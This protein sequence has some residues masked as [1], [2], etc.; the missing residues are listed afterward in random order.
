[1]T[2]TN[3]IRTLDQKKIEY[4]I[5]ELKNDEGLCGVEVAK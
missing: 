3:A 5:V 1:M 4:E 2:K